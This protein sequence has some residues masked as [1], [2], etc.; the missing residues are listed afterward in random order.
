MTA[1]SAASCRRIEESAVGTIRSLK[2]GIAMALL[3]SC[4]EAPVP[5]PTPPV[6][7]ELQPP[8]TP[9]I[10]AAPT[11]KSQVLQVAAMARPPM[12]F[13]PNRG[14][15]EPGVRFLARGLGQAVFLGDRTTANA[16]GV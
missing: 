8:A 16:R 3:A 13:E 1:C 15:A 4:A 11:S 5:S 12:L 14:Q 9:A 10:D 7:A 2:I 6:S